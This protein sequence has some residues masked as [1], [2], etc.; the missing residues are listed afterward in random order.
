MAQK[1]GTSSGLDVGSHT[2]LGMSPT[3]IRSSGKMPEQVRK[4]MVDIFQTHG[5]MDSEQ[6]ERY[7]STLESELRWQ[8][9][10]W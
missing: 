9:E 6:A 3:D 7:L 5:H 10:C 1:S 4:A 2:F 8:E